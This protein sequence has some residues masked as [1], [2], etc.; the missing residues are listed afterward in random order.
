M[1]RQVTRSD[2]T[3][4]SLRASTA[5]RPPGASAASTAALQRS[6][7]STISSGVPGA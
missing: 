5:T 4:A 1:R 7:A 3:G 6:A 2:F